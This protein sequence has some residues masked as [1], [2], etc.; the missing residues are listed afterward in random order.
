M[1]LSEIQDPA[2]DLSSTGSR[3]RLILRPD[4]RGNEYLPDKGAPHFQLCPWLPRAD[5]DVAGL[6]DVDCAGRSVGLGLHDGD[7]VRGDD[8]LDLHDPDHRHVLGPGFVAGGKARSIQPHGIAQVGMAGSSTFTFK[9]NVRIVA[10][11][12]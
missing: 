3:I 9:S 5:A 8:L 1:N 6:A 7:G 10:T 4:S 2:Y 12:R 11:V